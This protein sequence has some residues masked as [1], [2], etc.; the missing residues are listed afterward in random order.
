[1]DLDLVATPSEAH[2]ETL[3]FLSSAWCNFAI[4]A[5]Q[6]E[7]EERS[8]ILHH[9]HSIKKISNDTYKPPLPKIDKTVGFDDSSPSWKSNDLKSWIWMQQ[10][11]HPELNYNGCFRKKWFSW[12]IM[13]FKNVSIKKWL[14][15]IKQKRK[16]EDRLQRAEV[17]AAISVAGLAAALAAIAAENSK[18]VN[19]STTKESA[20][21]TAAALVAAQC[22]QV[23]EAMG[24]KREE[25]CTVIGSAMS[26]NSAALRGAATLKARTGCRNRLNGSAPILPVEGNGDVEFDFDK[27]RSILAKGAELNIETS[28]GKRAVRSV[29]VVL[30]GDAKVI[31]KL[32]KLH[33]L[34]PFASKMKSI[35]LDMHVELYTES[36]AEAE[37]EETEI[38]CHLIVLTTNCGIIKLDMIDDYSLCQMW[39]KTISQMLKLSTSFA[40]YELPFPNN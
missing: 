24:A 18:G 19:S 9:D 1:M 20:V 27:C 6:P 28:D 4:Q 7:L 29:S 36:E 2:P 40:K 38:T 22:E 21:A 5:L 34:S 14:K 33:M 16:E 37:A 39:A 3:D 23:A 8:L 17:H 25:L 32:R 13:P 35:V 12:K 30:H 31:L 26:G 10:A 15:E 11:M